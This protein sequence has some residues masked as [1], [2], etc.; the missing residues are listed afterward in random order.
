MRGKG[1]TQPAQSGYPKGV[2]AITTLQKHNIHTFSNKMGNVP[3]VYKHWEYLS[4]ANPAHK[5]FFMQIL[6]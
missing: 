1:G 4:N 6:L 5:F 3:E 2:M